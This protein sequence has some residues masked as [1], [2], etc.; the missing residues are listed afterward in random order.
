MR[1]W[2]SWSRRASPV[3]AGSPAG[4][5]RRPTAGPGSCRCSR[6]TRTRS[7]ADWSPRT[8]RTSRTGRRRARSAAP[9]ARP[10]R[11]TPAT[12]SSTRPPARPATR[13]ASACTAAGCS[14]RRSTPVRRWCC[15]TTPGVPQIERLR[16]VG[17]VHGRTGQ[18]RLDGID[19]VP[20][21]IRNCGGR[22]DHPTD[23]PLHDFTCT[24]DGELVAFTPQFGAETPAGA[25]LEAILDQRARVV[26]LRSPRGGPLPPGYRS[27]QATGDQIA[28]LQR[29]GRGRRP[30]AGQTALTDRRSP[31]PGPPVGDDVDRQRRSGARPERPGARHAPARRVR[32]SR[33]TRASTTASAPNGT[34]GPSPGSTP[35]AGPS[36]PPP[37]A[38]AP[39]ASA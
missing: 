15:A 10:R 20:G 28:Q 37:T 21:L 3:R 29:C 17:T 16:W 2:P 4:T 7:P 30:T 23:L 39:R 24:D 11:S 31:P 13:P 6:S 5:A 22:D 19:R 8:D 35:A 36:W 33:P 25:G 34:R 14:A 12:S 26:S 9:P 18:L 38:A 1:C 32:P 27:V